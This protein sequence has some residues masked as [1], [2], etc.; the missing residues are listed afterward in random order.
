MT[1]KDVYNRIHNYY[2]FIEEEQVAK[3]CCD[4]DAD[5]REVV[6][7]HIPQ[8]WSQHEDDLLVAFPYDDVYMHLIIMQI[9]QQKF[10]LVCKELTDYLRAKKADNADN[11]IDDAMG[12]DNV[13]E[14]MRK[15]DRDDGD[16]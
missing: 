5:L 11:D 3:E 2:P 15:G 9:T 4:F 6:G 7:E 13:N 1:T 14:M 10:K 12:A 8:E 16:E